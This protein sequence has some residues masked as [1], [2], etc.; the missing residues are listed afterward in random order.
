M[1]N[2]KLTY[3]NQLHFGNVCA[4]VY[5]FLQ[6]IYTKNETPEKEAKKITSFTVTSKITKCLEGVNCLENYTCVSKK[7]WGYIW[8]FQSWISSKC[9]YVFSPFIYLQLLWCSLGMLGPGF[10]SQYFIGGEKTDD[11][12]DYARTIYDNPWS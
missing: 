12:R 10:L 2:I 11:L 9:G 7:C 4:C 8:R 6:I 5:T 1:Q 3:K